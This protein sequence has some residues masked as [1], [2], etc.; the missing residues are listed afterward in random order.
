MVSVAY[1]LSKLNITTFKVSYSP[2]YANF[3]LNHVAAN[4]L[5]PLC[6]SLRRRQHA[7]KKEGLLW[8]TTNGTDISKSACVRTWARRRLRHAFQEELKAKGY[9]ETGRLAQVTP[10]LDRPDVMNV[11]RRGRSVDLTGTL[12]M[13]G[14]TP[15]IPAK[16]ETVKSEMRSIIEA[17]LQSSVDTALGFVGEAEKTSGPGQRVAQTGGQPQSRQQQER[18]QAAAP[19]KPGGTEKRPKLAAKASKDLLRVKPQ[20]SS[21]S[22]LPVKDRQNGPRKTGPATSPRIKPQAASPGAVHRPQRPSVGTKKNK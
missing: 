21:Q 22:S 4:P 9:D 19:A 5:H 18:R 20:T 17:M 12:R 13:H 15:L 1:R 3:I 2:T 7:R 11:L 8:H 6:A 16:F 10:M 14:V